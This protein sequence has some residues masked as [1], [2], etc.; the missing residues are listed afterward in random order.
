MRSK[1][2][3]SVNFS[4]I[5]LRSS[6]ILKRNFGHVLEHTCKQ[7]KSISKLFICSH[8]VIINSAFCIKYLPSHKIYFRELKGCCSNQIPLQ[9][10]HVNIFFFQNNL[11]CLHSDFKGGSFGLLFVTLKLRDENMILGSK[12]KTKSF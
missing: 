12:Y 8:L 4:L 7:I 6:K 2:D 11:S 10:I 5:Y 3:N 9:P 1:G